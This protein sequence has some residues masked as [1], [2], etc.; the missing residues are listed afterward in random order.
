MVVE[1]QELLYK[2]EH[3]KCRSYDSVGPG[4]LVEI[5]ELPK[6][7]VLDRVIEKTEI[8]F[9]QKGKLLLSFRETVQKRVEKG[10]ILLFPGGQPISA[11]ATENTSV[12]VCRFPRE[13]N[14]CEKLGVKE[15]SPY[16]EN[17]DEGALNRLRVN[18]P[19]KRFLDSFVPCVEEEFLCRH[20]LTLKID[21]LLLL[22]RGYYGKEELATFFYP[23]LG[24]DQVFRNFVYRNISQC[25]T[26]AELQNM[27]NMSYSGFWYR[28]RK[29][30][31]GSPREFMAR[32]KSNR[33]RHDLLCSGLALKEIG[34]KYGFGSIQTFTAFC[35]KTL[36]DTPGK[37]R[38]K[39]SLK[40]KS[41]DSYKS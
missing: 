26:I 34:E 20:F 39:E 8:V 12:F 10:D 6:G 22:F 3:V 13:I 1:K 18:K 31:G 30:M 14:F 16:A 35:K 7:R 38:A 27:C 25:K 37:I 40:I 23:L 17:T 5:I 24:H 28:F 11:T 33:I 41:S 15:L 19:I 36:G 21:E 9:I 32:E 4:G 29:V 2:P